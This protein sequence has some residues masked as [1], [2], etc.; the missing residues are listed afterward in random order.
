MER[1]HAC[2]CHFPQA[3]HHKNSLLSPTFACLRQKRNEICSVILQRCR[4][5]D[6]EGAPNKGLILALGRWRTMHTFPTSWLGAV[7]ICAAVWNSHYATAE[8]NTIS[9]SPPLSNR[10]SYSQARIVPGL[11]TTKKHIETS[12]T[13]PRQPMKNIPVRHT[14]HQPRPFHPRPLAP[15]LDENWGRRQFIGPRQASTAAVPIQTPGA[16]PD[17]RPSF[18][19]IFSLSTDNQPVSTRNAMPYQRYDYERMNDTSRVVLRGGN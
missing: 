1:A 16:T 19:P 8:S 13:P 5:L 10:S 2:P 14:T 4:G 6:R 9:P 18:P 7:L 12:L 3:R 17:K 11:D 15:R